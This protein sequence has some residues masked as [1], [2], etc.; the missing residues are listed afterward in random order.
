MKKFLVLVA[1]GLLIVF[2]VVCKQEAINPLTGEQAIL[3][4][5]GKIKI[6][7]I[8]EAASLL[9]DEVLPGIYD[10]DNGTV[11][12]AISERSNTSK[13]EA[14]PL[15][16]AKQLMAKKEAWQKKFPNK[17]IITMCDITRT[18]SY[19][20]GWVALTSGILIHYE[21]VK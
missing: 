8:E 16:T 21:Y 11:F 7:N 15:K 2:S 9:A 13:L 10:T 1:L 12:I 17:K 6:G 18:L 20:A 14:D 19:H 5:N 4:D 3:D